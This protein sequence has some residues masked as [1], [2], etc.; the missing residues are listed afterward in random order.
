MK[1]VLLGILIVIIL[2]QF[3][4]PE[5]NESDIVSNDI[6]TVMNVPNNVQQIIKT[7]CADCHSNKTVYPWYSEIAP[8]SWFLASHVNDGKEHLNFSEWSTYNDN[9]KSH[10]IKD[11]NKELKSHKMPLNSYLW[12]HKDAKMTEEQ[13]QIMLDWV[14]TMKE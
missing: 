12:I 11:L 1:K 2:I 3:I 6:K 10:I 13:Y 14:K 5:K 9:Q 4:R 8:I 7:S